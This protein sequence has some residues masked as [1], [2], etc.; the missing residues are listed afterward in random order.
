M[1]G[2]EDAVSMFC[3]VTGA[4]PDVASHYLEAFAWNIDSAIAHFLDN[5][6]DGRPPGPIDGGAQ[7]GMEFDDVEE[8]MAPS[9]RAPAAMPP[10]EPP[11]PH[12][13]DD[14]QRALEESI[15]ATGSA[16]M[17][18]AGTGAMQAHGSGSEA[19][20]LDD[21]EPV[22]LPEVHHVSS[23]P[24]SEDDPS[25]RPADELMPEEHGY[26]DLSDRGSPP[27]P[28]AR[29][30]QDDEPILPDDINAEEARMLEA[31]MIGADFKG[32]IPDFSELRVARPPPVVSAATRANRTLRA[33]QDREY[34]ESLRADREKVEAAQQAAMK[35]RESQRQK[36]E[37]AVL[38]A[39]RQAEEAAAIDRLM[40]SK[41]ASLPSEPDDGDS[42]S[43]TVMVRLP[44]GAR[45]GRRFRQSD[46]LS[47]LFDF[48]DIK[49]CD[50][51]NGSSSFKPGTYNL[52][53]NYPRR[54]FSLQDATGSLQDA[55][56]TS[57]QEALF[58]ESK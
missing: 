22:L 14:L 25:Y 35:A 18:A 40:Q 52:V 34:E 30:P 8:V 12:G 46:P 49:I 24:N 41:R 51:Q 31:V 38:E 29:Q 56:L 36:S 44:Q 33:E 26:A 53:R 17:P 2:Q 21:D 54:A 57:K 32:H 37:E 43:V 28:P 10:G 6:A 42:D 16:S 3:D 13:D 45:L 20:V 48:I 27:S 4:D 19:L 9:G 39:R 47:A 11:V 23:S 50:T 15:R 55:G 1:E 7:A 5:P 58:L